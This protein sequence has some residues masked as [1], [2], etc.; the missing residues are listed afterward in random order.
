M[1]TFQEY[2]LIT[3]NDLH[4]RP[5]NRM[6]IPNAS[7]ACGM[8][9]PGRCGPHGLACPGERDNNLIFELHN[10]PF[11]KRLL[12]FLVSMGLFGFCALM[13]GA[14]DVTVNEVVISTNTPPQ[15]AFPEAEGFGAYARGGRGG[16]HLYVTTTKDGDNEGCLR[17]ALAQSGRRIIEFKVGG[18]FELDSNLR[19]K[20][21]FFT[22]DG[23]TAPDGG[24][25]LKDGALDILETHDVI[26]R[27]LRVRPGD[28]ASL[29]KGRWQGHPRPVK[30]SDAVTVKDSADV[31]IDHVSAS[32]STDETISVTHSRRVTV[33]NCF[34]TEPLAN[35]ALHIE[36]GREISHPYGALVEGDEISYLKNYFA[37]F[38]IRGPQLAAPAEGERV[39]SAAV[40]NLVAFYENSGTRVKASHVSADFLVCSN[41][42]RYPLKSQA[43]DIHVISEKI[44]SQGKKRPGPED[45]IGHTR[46]YISGNLG[47]RRPQS[48]F[49]EWAGVR[50]D[51]DTNVIGKLR[52]A[53]PPFVVL[54]LSPLPVDAVEDHVLQNAGATLPKRDP[55]DDR[56]V[57]QYRAG[58]G[59]IIKSQDEVGGYGVLSD[60]SKKQ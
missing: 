38:K 23:S 20:E 32:W 33:Q 41:L 29:G 4:W 51:F 30:A 35:P 52:V 15:L 9:S 3:P 31:I 11:T 36:E 13:S 24:V 8:E 39:R 37:Y 54:P 40:N 47:P 18:V 28:E 2:R 12:Y 57:R 43:P 26:I 56:L 55:I 17:W 1:K 25:T 16:R 50:V 14:K 60:G 59:K 49:D 48:T 53:T 34:I 7:R 27:Y 6:R 21:P 58:T 46:I 42:Y 45:F 5:S 10:R 44:K 22:L 19:V